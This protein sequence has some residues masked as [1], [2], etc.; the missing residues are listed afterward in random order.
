M[1]QKL[2]ETF[3]FADLLNHAAKE[4]N[5]QIRLAYVA[6][7]CVCGYNL[8]I[9]RLTKFFNPILG[10]TFEYTDNKLNFRYIG[11]QVSHH[12][13][14][15]AMHCE[16]D[17]YII[18]ANT[19][20][21]AK[22]NL[23]ENSL[24]IEPI[25]RTCVTFF[26]FDDEF[27][28][29]TKPNNVVRNI[30]FGTM[31]VEVIGKSVITNHHT[32]DTIEL[33]FHDKGGPSKSDFGYIDGFLR[34]IHSETEQMKFIANWNSAHFDLKYKDE[35]NNEI[36]KTIWKVDP[37]T[38]TQEELEARYYMSDF[39][40][41]LNNDDEKLLKSLPRSDTRL[42]PDQRALE[43]NDFELAA[44]EK[45]RL[46]EKQRAM[47]KYEAKN[48]IF[49]KPLYFTETYDDITGELTYLLSRNY[50]EDKKNNNLDHFPDIF[51]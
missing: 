7:F 14:I 16:G 24:E 18:Y 46:E 6:A 8:H 39:T 51:S 19:N 1:I 20:A 17:G 38:L 22:F 2:C 31:H 34:S 15:T 41:N 13:A 48:N 28:T 35:N 36:Q 27:I 10:E 49:Y 30:M 42:R 25:G 50:W 45:H 4:P 32:G 21:K 9:H 5:P 44:K 43:R 12:P 3:R 33:T 29:I 40:L 23:F 47:R 26:N 37:I 11:E